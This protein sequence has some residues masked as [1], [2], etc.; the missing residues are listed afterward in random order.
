MDF[1]FK[2]NKIKN[3]IIKNL[4]CPFAPDRMM[5]CAGSVFQTRDEHLNINNNNLQLKETKKRHN[6]H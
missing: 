2:N 6:L 5:G 4:V 3:R 1:E